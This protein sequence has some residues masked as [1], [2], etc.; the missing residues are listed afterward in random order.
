MLYYNSLR[1]VKL[2]H[3]TD[4]CDKVVKIIREDY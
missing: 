2:L 4:P 3:P 1:T